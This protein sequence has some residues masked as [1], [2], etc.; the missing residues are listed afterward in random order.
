[1]TFD[2]IA[3]GDYCLDLIFTGLP[4]LPELGAEIASTG[5]EMI[6]GATYNA[7]MAMHRLGLAVGWAGDF[8]ND[9]FSRFV[10][11]RCRAEGLDTT[12]FVRHRRPMRRVTVALS[13]TDDRAFVAFYDPEAT[14]PAAVKALAH[15]PAR[16]IYVPGIV[17][18]S[19]F[20]AGAAIAKARHM[21]LVMDG[22][23]ADDSLANPAVRRS[24]EQADV[25]LPNAREARCL[26]G[27]EDV[28]E[29]L[30]EL[31]AHC[32]LV[33]IKDGPQGAYAMAQGKRYYAPALP[34]IPLDTTGAG[35]CFSAGFV[36]AWLDGRPI[37]ECLRWGNIVG[38]L[39][40]LAH[41]GAGRVVTVKDV[42]EWLARGWG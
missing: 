16:S 42:E 33:V 3:I 30:A 10:L 39:S 14:I 28:Q 4:R 6:P 12:L 38:G 15:V 19:V 41:G 1:M 35:D 7:V 18:H 29:A 26:T 24:I 37:E 13:Y 21:K 2:V 31:G 8:G 22:N 17:Y 27:K 25:L 20:H 36:K 23:A 32:P 5:F 34:I 9:D 11:E 40:T